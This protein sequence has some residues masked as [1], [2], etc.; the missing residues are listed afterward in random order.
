MRV[1]QEREITRIGGNQTIPVDVRIIAATNRNLGKMVQ[2]GD[3]REDLYY[4]LNILNIK[5]PSLREHLE[6]I[7]ELVEDILEGLKNENG[8]KKVLSK[9]VYTILQK[10]SWPG[11][12]RELNNVISKLYY[13]S[14]GDEITAV[15]V[16]RHIRYAE[17]VSPIETTE[18]GLDAMV[19]ELEKH[20]V[21]ETLRKNDNNI[22]KTANFLKISRPRLYRIMEK[23]SSEE[24]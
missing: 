8:T 17:R 2:D 11:N 10:Y 5:A 4:R 19:E 3:F 6:D 16:P 21:I 22:T 24:L 15:H 14:D 9:E 12:V 23:I 13:M 1:L 7:P 18:E 20:L